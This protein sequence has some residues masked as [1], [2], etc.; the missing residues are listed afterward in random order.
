MLGGKRK[1]K[2]EKL[3]RKQPSA[4]QLVRHSRTI[5]PSIGSVDDAVQRLLYKD[6]PPPP[7]TLQSRDI[8]SSTANT[9]SA[10]A[11][12]WLVMQYT[13]CYIKSLNS[14]DIMTK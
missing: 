14:L 2:K 10:S 5:E 1:E 13:Y 6:R 7:E 9:R 3:F 4:K 8:P 11:T 12:Y